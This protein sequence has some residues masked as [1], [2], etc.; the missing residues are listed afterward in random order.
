MISPMLYTKGAQ[1]HG[2]Q[3]IAPQTISTNQSKHMVVLLLSAKQGDLAGEANI[4]TTYYYDQQWIII[5]NT[6]AKPLKSMARTSVSMSVWNIAE[7]V[8]L[9]KCHKNYS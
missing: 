8:T 6:H 1:Q 2:G 9:T 7:L 5:I 4:D 3:E